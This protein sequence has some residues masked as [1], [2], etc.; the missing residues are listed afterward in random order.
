MRRPLCQRGIRF[1][2]ACCQEYSARQ[3]RARA[4]CG[5]ALPEYPSP[6]NK[7]F[8]HVALLADIARQLRF[9]GAACYPLRRTPL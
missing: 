5:S 2:K 3:E 6:F 9:P 7:L 4:N 8:L 1:G